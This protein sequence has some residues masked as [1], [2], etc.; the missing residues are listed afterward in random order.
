MIQTLHP[1]DLSEWTGQPSIMVIP[2]QDG[3]ATPFALGNRQFDWH[4]HVRGQLFCIQDGVMQVWTEHASWLL[5]PGT[6]GW[7][8]PG[9]SH[10]VVARR[11]RTGWSIYLDPSAAQ[12]LPA[13]TATFNRNPLIEL[14]VNRLAERDPLAPLT[15][16]EAHLTTVLMDELTVSPNNAN[17]LPLPSDHRLKRITDALIN[18]PASK[19]HVQ[20][21]GRWVGLSERSIHRLFYAQTGMR[22][23]QWRQLLRLHLAIERLDQAH[24]IAAVADHL[25]YENTSHFIAQFKHYFGVAPGQYQRMSDT[26]T[27]NISP[28][29]KLG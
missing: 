23:G 9:M 12:T 1:A 4:Q 3:D 24:A 13:K 28:S 6:L 14:I 11:I 26:L 16:R 19:K 21:W 18:Q 15:E 25:G 8:P 2:G 29:P 20:E 17:C 7:I 22:L 27:V 10:R 5:T